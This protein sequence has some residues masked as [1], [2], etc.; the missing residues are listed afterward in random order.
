M[1]EIGVTGGSDGSRTIPFNGFPSLPTDIPTFIS[2]FFNKAG[3]VDG[4]RRGKEVVDYTATV[5]SSN[6]NHKYLDDIL[7]LRPRNK[8]TNQLNAFEARLGL[9]GPNPSTWS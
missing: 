1:T 7:R 3:V 8:I 9:A 5:A 4:E 6:L 2:P